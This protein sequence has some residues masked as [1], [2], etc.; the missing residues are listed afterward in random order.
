M[1]IA[2]KSIRFLRVVERAQIETAESTN[3]FGLE[4][5]H[6]SWIWGQRQIAAGALGCEY[7]CGTFTDC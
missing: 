6:F 3:I 2:P 4:Q 1:A 5:R 7:M